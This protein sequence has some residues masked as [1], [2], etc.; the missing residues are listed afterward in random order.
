MSPCKNEKNKEGAVVGKTDQV[1]VILKSLGM[2]DDNDFSFITSDH[3]VQY[4]KEL[5]K[6]STKLSPD[7]ALISNPFAEPSFNQ[8][9]EYLRKGLSAKN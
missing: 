5:Q 6:S 2:Q 1:K 7:E 4:A 3:A 8:K 9:C